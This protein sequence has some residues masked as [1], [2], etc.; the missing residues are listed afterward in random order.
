MGLVLGVGGI[1][2][3]LHFFLGDAAEI[4]GQHLFCHFMYEVLRAMNADVIVN[5]LLALQLR[6][7]AREDLRVIGDH[8]AVVVVIAQTLVEVIGQA[9]VED[10]VQL[11]L[12]QGL[13]VAVA[14]LGR[15]AGGIAGDGSL[16]GQ[17][18][19][20]AGHRA[21]VD[22][23][24]EL[25]PEGVPEG[26]H[27]VHVQAERDA[28][29]AALAGH[30]LVTGQKLLLVGV[31]VQAVVLA[32]AG[33]GLIAAVAG[34]ELAAIR[35]GVHG[36][37]AV[38]AAAAALDADDLLIEVFQLLLVH[39]RRRSPAALF[40]LAKA[41]QG[42]AVSA[43]QARDVGADDLDAHFLFE[44]A[45]DGLIVEGAALHHDLPA[46][47]FG[48]GS[49]DDLV[50]RILDDADGQAGGDVLDGCAILLRLLD[51][52]VHEDGTAAAQ[53]HRAVRKQ[54]QRRELLD[55]VAQRLC[56]GLQ[57][58]AAAGGA[59]L[60][61]EDVADGP[62][63]DLEALHI[64]SADVDDEIDIR[65]E[66][67]GGGEVGH[68]LHQ[69]VIAAEG[70]LDQLLAVA[71]GGHAGHLKAGMLLVDL[72]ELFPDQGQR[73]AEVRLIVGV[74]DLALFV[75]DHQLDGGG[76]GVDA[77][78]DRAA[79][80]AEGHM[81]HAVGHMAGV[82]RLI[83]LLGGKERRL[84]GVG[85]GGGILIQRLGHVGKAERLVRVEGSA[86]RHIEQTVLRAGAGN[87]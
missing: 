24:A 60:V 17:I 4:L 19:P 16:T 22:G 5:E 84:A 71:G 8:R 81:R 1:C 43:H 70:I 50:Q 14:E 46:Q 72:D 3:R 26:Q 18:Q 33:H 39:H 10:G 85:G 21:G 2:G 30:R 79:L 11:H 15:E 69:T 87:A 48:A 67:F 58:A 55:V 59:R 44:G 52:A 56:E 20:P 65:H 49:A 63:L 38:V 83:L 35:E 75:H 86:Q 47:L 68:R 12:A 74:Q 54:A 27:L 57:E 82:E 6:A 51:R 40:A 76:T 7:V 9:G 34:D 13:D 45:E 78:M 29:G 77:D 36:E 66:V 53:I 32:L 73:V 80:R 31:Q 62:I 41:E 28:D 64:L 37:L 23:K 61:Q 42:R 25:G